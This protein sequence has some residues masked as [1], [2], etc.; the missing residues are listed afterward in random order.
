MDILREKLK[1]TELI[2]ASG[3]IGAIVLFL[4]VKEKAYSISGYLTGLAQISANY[5]LMDI[6][7]GQLV[8]NGSIIAVK[9]G[10]LSGFVDII[11]NHISISN[12]KEG[13]IV[14]ELV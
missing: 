8:H 12:I 13:N 10:Y 3:I 6:T 7:G 1:R 4:V 9:S 11:G 5:I 2:I 14:G